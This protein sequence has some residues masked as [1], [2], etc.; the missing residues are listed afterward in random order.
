M[1]VLISDV[2]QKRMGRLFLEYPSG[3]K[4]YTCAQCNTPLTNK[5]NLRSNRFTGS[6][7]RAFLF[8][9]A[10]NIKFSAT[11]ER[12]MLTGRHTV[13]DVHCIVCSEKLGWSYEY[14]CEEGQ[15][16]KE[17][18][19][20]LEKLLIKEIDGCDENKP[21]YKDGQTDSQN[22]RNRVSRN[23]RMQD[24]EDDDDNEDGDDDDLVTDDDS[25]EDSRDDSRRAALPTSDNQVQDARELINRAR[26][27]NR[28]NPQNSMNSRNETSI[29]QQ[30]RE[31]VT[32]QRVRSSDRFRQNTEDLI[33]NAAAHQTSTDIQNLNPVSTTNPSGLLPRN[34]SHTLSNLNQNITQNITQYLAPQNMQSLENH[35]LQSRNL[36]SQNSQPQNAQTTGVPATGLAYQVPRVIQHNSN[37]TMQQLLLAQSIAAGATQSIRISPAQ[38]VQI[39]NLISGA[40]NEMQ[41]DETRDDI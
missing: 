13:R 21:V 7:G 11:V 35:N 9:K 19:I 30:A 25:D 12:I 17:G 18:K 26:R 22:L 6:T 41:D 23:S 24:D 36:Q 31:T 4:I 8:D 3:E 14:A 27:W 38:S 1:N 39:L 33:R 40:S 15:R 2:N 28:Q 20:I 5:E 34:M 32:R 29:R 16:Y 10:V 37:N